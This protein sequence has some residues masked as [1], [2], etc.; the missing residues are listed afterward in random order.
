MSID[1]IHIGEIVQ[2]AF[3]QSNL[4]KKAFAE[5]IGVKSQ[6]IN[7]EFSKA[8]WSVIKL[9]SAGR[10]LHYDFSPLFDIEGAIKSQ[11][12]KVLLQIEVKEDNINEVLK[13]IGDR[14]LY[15][16]LKLQE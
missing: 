5:A 14:S 10:A 8:D 15:N 11:V 3:N 6:N 13:I 4:T 16:I 7:R 9:I 2:K 12:P 1:K